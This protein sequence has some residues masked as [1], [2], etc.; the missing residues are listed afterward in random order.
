MDDVHPP[1]TAHGRECHRLA[2]GIVTDAAH[3]QSS[4][5]LLID[6][7]APG[8]E[9]N[10]RAVNCKAEGE[11]TQLRR[12]HRYATARIGKVVV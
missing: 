6:P 10:R 2:A 1:P 12:E 5:D 3:E 7:P 9:E 8:F 11:A 4:L